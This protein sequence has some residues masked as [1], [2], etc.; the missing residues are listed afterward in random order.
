MSTNWLCTWLI[1]FCMPLKSSSNW[2]ALR[3]DLMAYLVKKGKFYWNG[4]QAHARLNTESWPIQS[5]S[6]TTEWLYVY[7][8]YIRLP[9]LFHTAWTWVWPT[10]RASVWIWKWLGVP[11][12]SSSCV[13]GGWNHWRC[14]KESG[15]KF[16]ITRGIPNMLINEEES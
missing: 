11:E 14:T 16:P 10:S 6:N 4:C 1:T 9:F 13:T 5:A 12:K 2:V 7:I 15:T 8:L 3:K